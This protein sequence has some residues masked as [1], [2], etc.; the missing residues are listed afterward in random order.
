MS[1]AVPCPSVEVT[2]I[3]PHRTVRLRR[4]SY[5]HVYITK[6]VTMKVGTKGGCL[7]A[8]TIEYE[9]KDT[10]NSSRRA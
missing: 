10:H 6:T 1:N 8:F 3:C 4:T 2:E 5:R 9:D 7:R